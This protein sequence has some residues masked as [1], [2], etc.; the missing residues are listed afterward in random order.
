MRAVI[1]T[2]RMVQDHEFLYPF[3]RLQEAGF[4]VDVAVRG[5]QP[6]AGIIGIKIEPTK[7][8]PEL[9]VEDYELLIIPGGVKAMEH[10]RLDAELVKFVADFHAAGKVIGSICSGAQ[11]LISAGVCRGRVIS[12]YPAIADDI[13]NAGATFIDWPAVTAEGISSK[14]SIVTSPHYRHLGPWMKAVLEE[15]AKH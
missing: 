2:G 11:M 5:K 14:G 1:V 8:V 4:E 12:G 13:R 6:C 15:V 9:R 7:D 3:Y 10:M